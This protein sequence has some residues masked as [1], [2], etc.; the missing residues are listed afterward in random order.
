MFKEREKAMR[1]AKEYVRK[2][3]IISISNK[4]KEENQEEPENMVEKY[5]CN[6]KLGLCEALLS[7]GDWGNARKLIERLPE[8]YALCFQPLA[9]ALCKLIH[10]I[11][12]P[13]Y[14]E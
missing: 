8:H 9:A 3:Q 11:I 5:N 2:L 7:I 1:D 6:Q 12:E 4:E 13:V 14:R 10:Y